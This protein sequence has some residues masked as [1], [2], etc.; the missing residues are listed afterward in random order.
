M[1]EGVILYS[2]PGQQASFLSK[3][4]NTQTLLLGYVHIQI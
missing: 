2:V 4:D 1:R 3:S